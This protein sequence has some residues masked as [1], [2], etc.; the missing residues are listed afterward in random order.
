MTDE[1][2]TQTSR[3]GWYKKA[4]EEQLNLL[5]T[6]WV[7][8]T[9][10]TFFVLYLQDDLVSN[11]L[12]QCITSS[13]WCLT[14]LFMTQCCHQLK[15]GPI[16]AVPHNRSQSHQ[17]LIKVVLPI[18]NG[19]NVWKDPPQYYSTFWICNNGFFNAALTISMT[20]FV[21]LILWVSHARRIGLSKKTIK[22]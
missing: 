3:R 6:C 10:A 1:R 19:G 2:K 15:S 18:R 5:L 13:L 8:K 9:Y 4:E 12:S 17:Y 21:H 16:R 7:M 22:K 20:E 11:L 14:N